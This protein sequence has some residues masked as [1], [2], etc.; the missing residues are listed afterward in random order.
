MIPVLS[1][2]WR[3]IPIM[4]VLLFIPSMLNPVEDPVTQNPLICQGAL[5]S[6]NIVPSVAAQDEANLSATFLPVR[7][8]DPEFWSNSKVPETT[9]AGVVVSS[10]LNFPLTWRRF[11]KEIRPL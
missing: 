5:T 9:I 6:A 8:V 4:E 3:N 10:V 11:S 2:T 1:V 7:S